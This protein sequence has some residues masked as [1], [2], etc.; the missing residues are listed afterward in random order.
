MLRFYLFEMYCACEILYISFVIFKLPTHRRVLNNYQR[1]VAN[2]ISESL[3]K[4]QRDTSAHG[5]ILNLA[6]NW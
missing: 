1:E 2:V 4:R 3:T 6:L 5:S